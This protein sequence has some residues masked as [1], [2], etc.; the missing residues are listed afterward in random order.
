MKLICRIHGRKFLF[1]TLSKLKIT[2]RNIISTYR[3][4]TCNQYQNYKEVCVFVYMLNCKGSSWELLNRS[5]I[6]SHII[7]ECYR[8]CKKKRLSLDNPFSKVNGRKN[9]RMKAFPMNCYISKVLL[10]RLLALPT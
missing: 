9:G 1:S 2:K 8:L 4:E 3:N 7:A 10:S 6:E 5:P